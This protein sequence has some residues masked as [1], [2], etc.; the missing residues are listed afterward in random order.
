MIAALSMP[1]KLAITYFSSQIFEV[2]RSGSDWKISNRKECRQYSLYF[3]MLQFLQKDPQVRRKDELMRVLRAFL[4]DRCLLPI[5]D[6][7]HLRLPDLLKS[8]RA[9]ARTLRDVY[10]MGGMETFFSAYIDGLFGL[11]DV[12]YFAIRA[13]CDWSIYKPIF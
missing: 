2:F 6:W 1:L 7:Q 3:V 12:R 5:P 4:C 8:F 13:L 10:L 9:T 11:M